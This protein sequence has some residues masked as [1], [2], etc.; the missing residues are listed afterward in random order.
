MSTPRI[1]H[2]EHQAEIVVLVK[3]ELLAIFPAC[4]YQQAE[5]AADFR[6]ALAAF[7]PDV[8]IANHH[9]PQLDGLALLADAL[10]HAPNTPVIILT[11]SEDVA[12]AVTYVKAGAVDFITRDN[13]RGLETAVRQAWQTKQQKDQQSARETAE[14][15]QALV[16]WPLHISPNLREITPPTAD[17]LAIIREQLDPAGRYR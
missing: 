6:D 17:E 1:L 16:G 3:D 4:E 13:L 8:I 14:S 2:V 12:T 10:A 15:I 9:L 11:D 5:N 7:Q